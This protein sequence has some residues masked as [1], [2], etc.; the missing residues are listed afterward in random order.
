MRSAVELSDVHNIVLV[1]E[2]CGLVV[3]NIEVIRRAEDGHYARESSGSCLAVHAVS[4]ILSFVCSD[5]REEIILFEEV[6]S[7][8]VGEEVGA[9][10]DV[11]V[12][13]VL[14]RLLLAELLERICP[15][16]IAH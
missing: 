5:D 2:H 9:S 10:S 15:E 6:A 14:A 3:V 16:D 4:G 1:L 7:G 11:I 12:H 8:G 13:E